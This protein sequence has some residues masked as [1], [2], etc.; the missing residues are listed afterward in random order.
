MWCAIWMMLTKHVVC[1]FLFPGLPCREWGYVTSSCQWPVSRIDSN[2]SRAEIA[3]GHLSPIS[4]P[5]PWWAGR[6]LVQDAIAKRW[7]INLSPWTT[8]SKIILHSD[9]YLDMYVKWKAKFIVES[10]WNIELYLLVGN[11]FPSLTNASGFV[12]TSFAVGW[13]M[14]WLLNWLIHSFIQQQIHISGL[15]YIMSSARDINIYQLQLKFLWPKPQS[16]INPKPQSF[17]TI[18][19]C[20]NLQKSYMHLCPFL[21]CF[22]SIS[23]KSPGSEQLMP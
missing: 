22:S 13:L 21:N 2:H 23:W 6:P 5:L 3:E 17:W 10:L 12:Y 14:Y 18:C 8:T 16:S 7:P 4:F 1:S 11:N 15:I 19:I 9:L 20:L